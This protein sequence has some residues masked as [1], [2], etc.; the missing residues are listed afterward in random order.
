[1]T[2]T[3]RGLHA[4]ALVG[5]RRRPVHPQL[6]GGSAGHEVARPQAALA[7]R[8]AAPYPARMALEDFPDTQWTLVQQAA[9]TSDPGRARE[10]LIKLCT[11]YY[12]RIV[13]EMRR[14]GLGADAETA[15]HDF[16]HRWVTRDESPLKDFQRGTTR[17]RQFLSVC[18]R[19]FIRDWYRAQPPA[20]P[21]MDSFATEPV[22]EDGTGESLDRG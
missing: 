8:R 6:D 19:N 11:H 5:S 9:D 13:N 12:D 14:A 15:A 21:A 20:S 1:V 18:I 7:N 17:F 10:A 2:P 3:L 4:Y 22:C 16:I